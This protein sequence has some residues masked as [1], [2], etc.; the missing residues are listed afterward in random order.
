MFVKVMD[1]L[2]P[3]LQDS[4]F[5]FSKE[6]IFIS[7]YTDSIFPNLIDSKWYVVPWLN[8]SEYVANDK[9]FNNNNNNNTL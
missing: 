5:D 8:W 9:L 7:K 1:M 4:N 2:Y 6:Y 3:Y